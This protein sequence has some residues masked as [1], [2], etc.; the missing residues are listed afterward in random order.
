MKTTFEKQP[1]SR[2]ELIAKGYRELHTSL[3]RKYVSRKIS[4]IIFPYSGRFGQG[5]KMLTPNY[6]SSYY[7]YITYFVK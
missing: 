5:Y 1:E 7:S 4:C 3:T 6:N 2:E